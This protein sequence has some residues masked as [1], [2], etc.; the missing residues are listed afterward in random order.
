M[1]YCFSTLGCTEY[2]LDEALALAQRFEI[3]ALELRGLCG[4]MNIRKMAELLPENRAITKQKFHK[5]GVV[6]LILGTSCSFHDESKFDNFIEEGIFAID[7]AR[8]IGFRGIRA[9]GNNI[10]GG[11]DECLERIARGISTL[12]EYASDKGVE[13]LLETHGDVNTGSRLGK[14]AEICGKYAN[15][16]LVWDVCHTR[17]TYS[18]NWRD[19]CDDFRTLIRH[20]HLKDVTPEGLVLPGKGTLPLREMAEYLV[21]NGY[22]GAFSLEWERKWHPELPPIEDALTAML[23]IFK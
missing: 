6:P 4:E 7:T 14:V 3:S 5:Y 13:V 2:S 8:E 20:V 23:E 16:G 9:F 11:E 21:A 22:D 17:N 10:K 19:F 12:C 15:F 1:K 18:E